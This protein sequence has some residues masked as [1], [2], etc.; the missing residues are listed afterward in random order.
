MFLPPPS[1][2]CLSGPISVAAESFALARPRATRPLTDRVGCYA[3]T[4]LVALWAGAL[5]I[6]V[7]ALCIHALGIAPL[8]SRALALVLSGYFAFLGDRS[9]AFRA[10]G[11]NA[12]AQ[13]RRFLLI[14]LLALPLNWLSFRLCGYCMPAVAPELLALAA[15]AVVFAAFAYPLRRWFVFRAALG[16]SLE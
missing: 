16:P 2:P 15:N 3:R 5:D 11:G 12:R 13:A 8:V 4:V 10:Q 14:E 7:L 1:V 9:F 6:A